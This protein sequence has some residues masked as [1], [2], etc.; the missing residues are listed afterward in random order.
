MGIFEGEINAAGDNQI[1]VTDK[2]PADAQ[3]MGAGGMTVN[4]GGIS[5]FC[6]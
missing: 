2:F 1:S 4:D 3:T 6:P 5:L